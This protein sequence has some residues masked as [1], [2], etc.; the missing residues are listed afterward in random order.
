M[1]EWIHCEDICNK[2]LGII[3]KDYIQAFYAIYFPALHHFGSDI[4]ISYDNRLLHYK[5]DSRASHGYTMSNVK[6][7]RAKKNSIG[8]WN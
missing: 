4:M 1:K 5:L 2:L 8:N 7:C 3:E 6:L